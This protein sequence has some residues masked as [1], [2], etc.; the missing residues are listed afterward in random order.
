M[1]EPCY[2]SRQG[3]GQHGA[4][5]QVALTGVATKREQ[6]MDEVRVLDAFGRGRHRRAWPRPITAPTVVEPYGSSMILWTK[7]AREHQD[8]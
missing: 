7:E 3:L 4:R 6:P 1:L 2:Q 8:R 5:E